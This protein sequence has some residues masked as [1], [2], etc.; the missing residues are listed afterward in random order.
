[1]A[2]L[3]QTNQQL[4]ETNKHLTEQL[5]QQAN[6]EVAQLKKQ[7]AYKPKPPTTTKPTVTTRGPRPPFDHAAWVLTLDP[8]G[9]CWT[10]GYKVV[11]GH[12]SRDCKSKLDG[13]QDGAT[14]TNNLGGSDKG[15]A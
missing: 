15:K 11:R 7:A 12:N 4:V 3:T 13:H 14:R 5:H 9:Y 2:Q 10:H 1:M 6:T 8:L